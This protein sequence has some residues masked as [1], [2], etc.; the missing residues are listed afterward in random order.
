MKIPF[1]AILKWIGS[2]LL[3]A[4]VQQGAER[5]VRSRRAAGTEQPVAPQDD[6]TVQA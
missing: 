5:I 6:I 4:A 3:T 1:V 2:T